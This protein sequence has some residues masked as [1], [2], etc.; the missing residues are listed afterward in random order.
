LLT[1]LVFIVF[2]PANVYFVV[3]EKVRKM[4]LVVSFF[5]IGF[6]VWIAENIS[7][8][9]G[10]WEYPNQNEVWQ[11]VS[12]GKISSWALMVIIGVIIVFDLKLFKAKLTARKEG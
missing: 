11:L 5:L 9:F 4:K 2:W 10:A 1:G 6:F 12:L 3:T 8:L 7:T